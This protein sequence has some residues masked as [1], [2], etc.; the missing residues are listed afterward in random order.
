MDMWQSTI[1][2]LGRLSA[3]EAHS[4]AKAYNCARL[5]QAGFP[6]PDGVVVLS[7]ASDAAIAALAT[8]RWF[9]EM[10]AEAVFAV[11]SSGIG[12]DG[13]GESF[14]GIHQTLLGVR[15]GD[16][17]AA[18]LECRASAFAPQALEY[19]KAKGMPIDTIAMGVLVQR[20]IQPV[21]AGVAFTINP[22]T[23]AHDEIVIN[24]SWGLGEALVSGHV[25]P[26]EFVL[27]KRDRTMR[28]SRIGEKGRADGPMRASLTSDQVAELAFLVLSIEQHYGTPQDIEWCHDGERFWIVQSRPVTTARQHDAE[29]EWTRANLAEV[30][31]DLT[32]P[33]ALAEFEELLDV[34]ERQ[35]LGRAVA[36]EAELGRMVKAFHGRLY[37]NLSQLRR[38]CAVGGASPALML[39]SMGHADA[40]GPSDEVP[41]RP[42]FRTVLACLP[43]LLRILRRHLRAADI[44]RQHESHMHAQLARF[45][46][47]DPRSQSDATLWAAIEDWSRKSPDYMQPVL[48][49]GGVLFH[50]APVWKACATVGFPFEQLVY[51][52]L[53]VGARSVS[54]QQ[55]FDLVALAQIA[56]REPAVRSYLLNER[57]DRA[58]M[59]Q[60]LRGTAFL[61]AFDRFLEVYGHRGRYEYDW[62]LP[63]YHEDP[64]PLLH[65]L[66][67]H[68]GDDHP[69]DSAA[70][71]ARQQR[72]AD[73]AWADF[74]ARLTPWQ[75][76]TLLPR[77]KRSI[78]KIKQY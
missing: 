27:A 39:K 56:R 70:T 29:V 74:E 36:P 57:F 15:R 45:A 44:V 25:D 73:Q 32:S 10:D 1:V 22:V 75:R 37:F 30:L 52:Q 4:G 58:Q 12:E 20:M 67:A 31:P 17:P 35:F 2:P 19:R 62:S 61:N 68:L 21:V 14:A 66:R 41:S 69:E 48:L 64:S 9:D 26:D 54:A 77:V 33:Q 16:V 3:A 13:E 23:G 8:H 47:V 65:T 38:L 63:R 24:A 43:D 59:N 53:A 18:V 40:I 55:A 78:A 71:A 46:S 5:A 49:F 50:E 34:A 51:P 11:R 7:V 28:W 60:A 42:P 72:E 76:W 6:V